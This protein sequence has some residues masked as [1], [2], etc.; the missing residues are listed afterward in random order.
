MADSKQRLAHV[1]RNY[2][3]VMDQLQRQREDLY[4]T[5]SELEQKLNEKDRS[6]EQRNALLAQAEINL[7]RQSELT[8]QK[9]HRIETISRQLA[10]VKKDMRRS[11]ENHQEQLRHAK[12]VLLERC[13][14]LSQTIIEK[15]S[16]IA[17]LQG[18]VQET[19]ESVSTTR[20]ALN[21]T[22]NQLDIKTR[23]VEQVSQ[24]NADKS[25][26]LEYVQQQ[27]ASLQERLVAASK[28]QPPKL[29][30]SLANLQHYVRSV[31]PSSE[32]SSAAAAAQDLRPEETECRTQ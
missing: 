5:L 7:D 26:Q 30:R 14:T 2:Q 4:S 3:D 19:A 17:E 15:D 31:T 10:E 12:Q 16:K 23:K 24:E 8:T 25:R 32:S 13:Q 20:L 18:Q 1:A 22:R 6:L 28:S 21:Q 27:C 11:Q 29:E 9:E